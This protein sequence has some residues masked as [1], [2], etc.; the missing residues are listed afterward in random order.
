MHDRVLFEQT[1]STLELAVVSR[2]TQVDHEIEHEWLGSKRKLRLRGVYQVRA[3]F[4]LRRPFHVR[5]DGHRVSVELP[6]PRILGVDQVSVEVL[7]FANGL[8]NKFNPEAVVEETGNLP[9]LAR[10]K[11]SEAG[12][13]K[14]ALDRFTEQLREKFGPRYDVEVH[15]STGQT[16]IA[17]PR[18]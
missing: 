1:T 4:D 15:V 11:A 12:L 10:R 5:I 18:E 9:L 8:W 16:A 14:E 7:S 17:E 13:Q 6:P 3:G 2:E